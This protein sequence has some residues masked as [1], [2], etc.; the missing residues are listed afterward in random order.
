MQKLSTSKLCAAFL[1]MAIV[2]LSA[3]ASQQQ[4]TR[5]KPAKP[6]P[7]EA[8]KAPMKAK[9]VQ[10]GDNM[11]V[12]H[13]PTGEM[14]TSAVTL[15]N[16]SPR[17]V[18]L[19][20]PYDFVI[21]ATNLTNGDLDGVTVT[22]ILP[23][24]LEFVSSTP[25]VTTGDGSRLIWALGT[26]AP[27]EKRT[28]RVRAKANTQGDLTHCAEV[29]YNQAA[30]VK[31]QV[32][33][34]ALKLTKTMTPNVLTCDPI[35][36]VL[37]VSN[38]GTGTAKN[39][40]VRANLPAGLTMAN[41]QTS[42]EAKIGDLPGGSSR[43]IRGQLIATESGDYTCEAIATADGG[44]QSEASASTMARE[45]ALTITKTGP[46]RTFKGKTVTYEI[47]VK[48]VGDGEARETRV[49][50]RLPAG[51]SYVSSSP[52]GTVNGGNVSW[53]VGTLAVG[54]ERAFKVTVRANVISTITN[55][56]SANAYC[57]DEVRAQHTTD[58][59]GIPGI[60]ME[61]VDVED[62]IEVGKNVVYVIRVT[63]QGS[64]PD[65]NIKIVCE[66]EDNAQFVSA[67]GVT[68]GSHAN[69]TVT[70]SPLASLAAGKSA[71][72]RVTVKAVAEA[73]ARFKVART[74]DNTTRPVNETESTNFYEGN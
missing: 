55:N 16:S 56:V 10:S 66:M 49:M 64:A 1:M 14:G 30:C 72:W 59:R 52:A 13:V 25:D 28:I 41:G 69:G 17:V 61:V 40:V 11:S 53:N 50:D 54:D 60:L 65:T 58:V 5:R 4:K 57:A 6:A 67:S 39:V 26:L 3:C 19:G 22:D 68:T 47:M 37:T 7:V 71:E 38:N 21:T 18:N 27:G 44:L 70:F 51:T 20:T 2:V 43:E 73:D 15:T 35:E 74:T 63:N 8:K 34:P 9:M 24:G 31:V 36:V 32:V 12:L 33:E 48:N 62:P 29:T 45:P 23:Q 42:M 46:E